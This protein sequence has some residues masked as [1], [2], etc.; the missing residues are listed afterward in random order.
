MHAAVGAFAPLAHFAAVA[1][2]EGASAARP[3]ARKEREAATG[4]ESPL[5]GELLMQSRY[6]L[7]EDGG[8]FAGDSFRSLFDFSMGK[9]LAADGVSLADFLKRQMSAARSR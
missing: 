5:M 7:D 3:S 4:L 6:T 1:G 9:H 2:R 8:P